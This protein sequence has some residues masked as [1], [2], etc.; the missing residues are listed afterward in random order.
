MKRPVAEGRAL[1]DI[2]KNGSKQTVNPVE[3]KS[4]GRPPTVQRS[5]QI[6]NVARARPSKQLSYQ[7]P[8]KVIDVDHDNKLGSK[9]KYQIIVNKAS[10]T[11]ALTQ[12]RV[13]ARLQSKEKK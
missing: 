1:G 3:K 6:S 10:Q 9:Y 7:S 2:L 4:R 12:V 8:R 13:S 5:A 11:K